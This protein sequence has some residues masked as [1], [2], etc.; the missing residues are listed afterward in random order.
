MARP[1]LQ[2]DPR[3]AA[4]AGPYEILV[5]V[6]EAPDFIWYGARA[7]IDGS[8]VEV[9]DQARNPLATYTFDSP[10]ARDPGDGALTGLV[11]GYP[12][13]VRRDGECG[14]HGTRKVPK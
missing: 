1:I 12:L 6:I 9:R 7:V 10:P 5:A 8:T 11:D 3:A 2:G 14:C 13:L 4:P